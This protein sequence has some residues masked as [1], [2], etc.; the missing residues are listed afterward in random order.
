[1]LVPYTLVELEL[2]V[3]GRVPLPV[4]K[5]AHY[6]WLRAY[7][8]SPLLTEDGE[9]LPVESKINDSAVTL[10][11]SAGGDLGAASNHPANWFAAY[12]SPRHE[13][14]VARHLQSR[15]IENFLPIYTSI[16]RR[17][18]GCRVPVAQPLFPSYIFVHIP[19]RESVKVLE[20][21]GVVSLVSTGREPAALPNC[22]IESL[23]AGLP[24]RAFEPHPYLAAGEKVRIIS[25][26][27]V[28]MTGVLLRR[29]S[30]FRVVLTLD[31]IQQSVA[32]EVNL[33]EIEP[34]RQ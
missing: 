18:N 4:R 30:N 5:V 27:L 8:G 7:L 15:H 9:A 11:L 6:K 12:T 2:P 26:A 17:T 23:R 24:Q 21:P 33:E 1:L 34:F 16:R 19:R 22:E 32:V 10:P 20:V 28:G 25:G 3:K 14:V 13:K 29:K 31:L